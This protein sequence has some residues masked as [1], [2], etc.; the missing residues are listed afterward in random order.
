MERVV[1]SVV[2]A[3]FF[4]VLGTVHMSQ[5]STPEEAKAMAE[6]A[7]AYWKANGKDKAIAEFNNPQ[8]QFVKGDVYVVAHDFKGIVLAHGGNP[9]L[10]G[11]NL[12]EQKDPNGNK[13]FVQ[14]QIELA[15]T[16]GSG[17]VDFSWVNP[18]TKKV[19]PKTS[20][21]KKIDGAD[22]LINCG[23]FK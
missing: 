19:Q 4:V 20:W 16:K 14:E 5:A 1:C 18:Q 7:A 3:V 9:K 8:G 6:K 13:L 15:K 17:W 11:V 21:V 12:W 23:V 10:V 2:L 22:Y